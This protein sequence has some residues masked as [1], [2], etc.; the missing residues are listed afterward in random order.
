M[1]EE[2]N[3]NVSEEIS[4][5]KARSAL[6]AKERE[7][8]ELLK[9][10]KK[11]DDLLGKAK[12]LLNKIK[13][14]PIIGDLVDDI[15]TTIE[16]IGDYVKGNYREIPVG[17]IVSALAAIIYLVSP[18]DLIPDVIP[19]V[20]F[21]DDAV[22][23]AIVFAGGLSGELKKYREWKRETSSAKDL[24]DLRG[25]LEDKD[26]LIKDVIYRADKVMQENKDLKNHIEKQKNNPGG[27]N[28]EDE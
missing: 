24:A 14:I 3:R 6:N 17:I 25:E 5:E 26:E 23:L 16:L 22:V 15:A 18:I 1:N 20:G 2:M 27:V 11:T 8:K 21:L 19:I 12:K 9:D 28:G 13:K 7:A 10:A 4:E